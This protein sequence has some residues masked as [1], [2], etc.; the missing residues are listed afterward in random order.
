MVPIPDDPETTCSV[1][2]DPVRIVVQAALALYLMPVVA[3]VCLIGGTSI[4]AAGTI[5]MIGQLAGNC[6][7]RQERRSIA[8][9]RSEVGEIGSRPIVG[10]KRSRVV[11]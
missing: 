4:L 2:A 8:V 9:V 1:Q 7:R 5:R 11:P 3:I 10:R 6:R